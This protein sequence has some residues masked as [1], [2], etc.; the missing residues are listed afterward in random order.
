MFE[1]PQ[2]PLLLHITEYIEGVDT[3]SNVSI[4][5]TIWIITDITILLEKIINQIF[6]CIM[7]ILL[8]EFTYCE[9]IAF[10]DC[11]YSRNVD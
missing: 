1:K 11:F 8:L 4:K 6:L 10:P 2:M 3:L 5:S 9:K 7:H